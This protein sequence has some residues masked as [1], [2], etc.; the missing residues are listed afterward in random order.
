MQPYLE[1]L[2]VNTDRLRA[3]TN[4]QPRQPDSAGLVR[5][6]RDTDRY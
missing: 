6:M 2:I 4:N 5:S 1:A 3:L